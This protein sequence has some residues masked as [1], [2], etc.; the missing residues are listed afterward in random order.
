MRIQLLITLLLIAVGLQPVI[1]DSLPTDTVRLEE[2]IVR[3]VQPALQHRSAVPMQQMDSAQ[4]ARVSGYS[5]AEALKTFSGLTI[6]DYGGIG[7]LKTVMVRSMG[8]NHTTVALDGIPQSDAATG[9]I[10]LGK[11]PLSNLNSISLYVGQPVDLLQPA[12]NFASSAVVN[13]QSNNSGQILQKTSAEAAIRSGSFGLINPYLGIITPLTAT[14]SAGLNVNYTR[15]HGE[16][17]FTDPSFGAT[18]QRRNSDIESFSGKL[19]LRHQLKQQSEISFNANYHRSERGLPGAVILYNPHSAQR[20][21]DD[22]FTASLRYEKKSAEDL[23]MLSIAKFTRSWLRYQEK[24]YASQQ[25]ELNNT[26]LQHE[27]YVSQALVYPFHNHFHISLASDLFFNTLD[28]NLHNFANPSRQSWLTN[29]GAQFKKNR[30]DLQAGLLASLINDEVMLGNAAGFYSAFSPAFSLAYRITSQDPLLRMRLMYKKIFRM[31]TFNDLYYSRVGNPAL[32]PENTR[33]LNFGLLGSY[34]RSH[35]LFVSGSIDVFHNAVTDKIVATP[36]QNLFVWSM[37]NIGEVDILGL[38]WQLQTHL[39]LSQKA[40]AE[41]FANYTFQRAI[42]LTNTESPW[43]KHQIPY[44]PRESFSTGAHT[45]YAALSVGFSSLFTGHRYMLAE[46]IYE[47][48]LHS[49]WHHDAYAAWQFS[50][51]KIK[52]NLKLEVNNVFDRR[53]EVIKSFPMPGRGYYI[54]LEAKI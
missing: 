14:T 3:A 41:L 2:V 39:K 45:T 12:R 36:T 46:N 32:K 26:Y 11:I 33:Q 8:A 29:L 17:P 19:T 1:A 6:K 21:W 35:T 42:D 20:L 38:E 43:Y 28:A 9:Q 25:G 40:S 54:K 49:W 15:A 50:P 27:Y 4:L 31:P 51:G 5:A 16:Y 47:N 13:I 52:L 34:S 18:S 44:I 7:G 53:Y 48:M 22:D 10:D 24:D 37:Q 23:Q 30:I